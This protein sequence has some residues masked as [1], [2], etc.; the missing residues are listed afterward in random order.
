MF[1]K[2]FLAAMAAA[3]IGMTMLGGT[4]N[5]FAHEGQEHDGAKGQAESV[6]TPNKRVICPVSG[7]EIDKGS[8]LT[9]DYE[10]K[11]YDLCCADCLEKFKT[12]PEKYIG[13]LNAG[14]TEEPEHHDGDDHGHHQ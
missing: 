14:G 4:D 6:E 12:D 9:Y 8:Q 1:R 5:V 2:K 10:G 13:K 3:I 11:V 7:E